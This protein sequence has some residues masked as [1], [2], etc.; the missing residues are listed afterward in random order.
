MATPCEERID[1]RFPQHVTVGILI[2]SSEGDL[3]GGRER[4]GTFFVEECGILGVLFCAPDTLSDLLQRHVIERFERHQI[5]AD[6]CWHILQEGRDLR[7]QR[8]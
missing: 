4:P 7:L 2:Q 3:L 5:T 6:R 8:L 1:I